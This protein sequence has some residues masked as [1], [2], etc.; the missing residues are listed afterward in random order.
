MIK[1][2]IYQHNV[3]VIDWLFENCNI[4]ET[5][6]ISVFP[7]PVVTSLNL[8]ELKDNP[9]LSSPLSIPLVYIGEA[10]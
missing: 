6:F 1:G 4:V 8:V 10:K 9:P 2:F 7:L 3:F 5:A